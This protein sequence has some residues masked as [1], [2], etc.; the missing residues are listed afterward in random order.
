M[1]LFEVCVGYVLCLCVFFRPESPCFGL[2]CVC[3]VF[4]NV[5]CALHV[6]AV[7][8]CVFSLLCVSR[9]FCVACFL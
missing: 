3:L 9:V 2:F 7:W 8:L 5:L 6:V 1:W 4:V